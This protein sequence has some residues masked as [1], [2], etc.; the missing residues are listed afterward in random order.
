MANDVG[1]RYAHALLEVTEERKETSKVAEAL[2]AL[3]KAIA[4]SAQLEQVILDPRMKADRVSVLLGLADAAAKSTA[5]DKL[6]AP[7]ALA[8]L[9]RTLDAAERMHELSNVATAFRRLADRKAG[10]VR[11]S[12]T[13]AAELGEAERKK[14]QAALSDTV[15]KDVAVDYHVDA[16]LIGGVVVKVQ[17]LVWDG[18]VRSQLERMRQTLRT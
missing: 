8:S 15:G 2:D 18:S 3:A 17:D 16:T 9:L 12:V 1:E 13:S 14:L 11:A 10:R 5:G 4:T 6:Q 7:A